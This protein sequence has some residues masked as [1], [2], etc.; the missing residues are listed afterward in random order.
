M[1][2]DPMAAVVDWLDAYRSGDLNAIFALYADDA[3]IQCGCSGETSVSGSSA[4]RAYLEQRLRDFRAEELE[5]LQ[6]ADDGAAI[7]YLSE[8]RRVRGSFEFNSH[9]KISFQRCGPSK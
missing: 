9:G 8:G 4:I 5:D 1:S 7:S 3:E 2:F 6:P